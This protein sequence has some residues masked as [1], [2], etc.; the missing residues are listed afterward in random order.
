M[1]EAVADVRYRWNM[2]VEARLLVLVTLALLALGLGP[3]YSAGAVVAQQ[4]GQSSAAFFLK[5]LAGAAVGMVVFGIFAKIDAEQW[6]RWAWPVMILSIVLLVIVI[7]P[8]TESIAPRWHGSRRFL[9]GASLQP[10]ELGKI[11][12]IVWTSMLVVKKGDAL[13]G[14]TK[15]LLPFLLVIGVLDILVALE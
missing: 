1:A 12:V 5:Q 9:V 6:C 10:S 13:Q 3:V 4:S 2:S 7:L 15:G 11:A 14:L 8:F